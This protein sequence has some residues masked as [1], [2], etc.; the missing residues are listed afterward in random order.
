MSLT[1][2]L[3]REMEAARVLRDQIADIAGNDPDFM[4]D[5]IEGETS[6]RELIAALAAE[7]GED[8]ALIEGIDTYAAGL[9]A[10]KDRLK[11]RIDTRRALI[12]KALEIAE[13]KKLETPTGTVSLTKVAPKAIVTDEAEI[14][15]RF[16]VQ[17]PAPPPKL[18]M[19]ALNEAARAKEPVPG[20]TATNGNLTVSIRRA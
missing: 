16:W 8:K 9:A 3:T 20:M 13:L 10:R 12:G 11:T 1:N 15:A 5:A 2:A 4:R 19:K 7:E 17:P 6:L 14:P 18:D